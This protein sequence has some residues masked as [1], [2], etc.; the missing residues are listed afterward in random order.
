[1]IT[2]EF[3]LLCIAV[4]LGLYGAL[5]IIA[6]LLQTKREIPERYGIRDGISGL[7]MIGFAVVMVVL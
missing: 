2:P 3:F 4:Y 6:G 1:M 7:I 5:K